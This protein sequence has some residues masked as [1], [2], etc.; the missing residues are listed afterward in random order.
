M[1]LTDQQRAFL[2]KAAGAAMI[3]LK[4]DGT[5]HA[6]RV[7]I[8][9]IDGKIWSSG[10]PGRLRTR[11]VRRDP[12]CAFFVWGQ[13][14]GFLT[15]EGRVRVLEGPEAPDQSVRLFEAMQA[16]MEKAA[17]QLFWQGKPLTIEQFRQAMVDEQRLIYELEIERGYGMVG[18]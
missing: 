14:H 1:E 11:F 15:L 17:G 16:R 7:G 2:A 6:V 12:R 5:P 13:G 18:V 8:A 10:V 9:L 4:R 3:T